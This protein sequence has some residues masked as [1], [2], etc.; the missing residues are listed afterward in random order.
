MLHTVDLDCATCCCTLRLPGVAP[1]LRHDFALQPPHDHAHAH[2][3][4]LCL[5][6]A[7][8]FSEALLVVSHHSVTACGDV[9]WIAHDQCRCLTA[10]L[11]HSDS[12][13]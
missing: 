5:P 10:H 2:Y 7:P 6:C 9:A 12:H 8:V 3:R 11:V 1:N 4:R 13:I